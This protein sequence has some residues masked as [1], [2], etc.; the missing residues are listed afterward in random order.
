MKIT[1]LPKMGIQESEK[2]AVD[3]IGKELSCDEQLDIKRGII[4]GAVD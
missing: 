4:C 1:I 3:R 2:Y